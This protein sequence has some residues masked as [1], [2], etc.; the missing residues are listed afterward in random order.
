VIANTIVFLTGRKGCGKSTLLVEIMR[1]HKRVLILDYLGEHGPKIGATVH[2]GLVDCVRAVERWSAKP[3]F[4]LSLRVTEETDALDLLSIVKHMRRVLL[5]VEEASWLCSPSH[6]PSELKELVRFGRHHEISQVYVAQRPAMVHRDITSQADVIVSFQQHEARDIAYLSSS[7][8]AGRAE[9]VRHLPRFAVIAGTAE[10]E[11]S[12]IPAAVT[13]RL[14][15]Q[16]RGASLLTSRG[17]SA[18]D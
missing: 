10:G 8:L 14:A 6:L 5:V 16:A 12:K 3:R 1:E 9:Q 13:R 18:Q 11:E 2:N 15:K 17:R 4:C 7:V